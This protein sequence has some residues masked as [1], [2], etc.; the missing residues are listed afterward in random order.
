[1]EMNIQIYRYLD[2]QLDIYICLTLY[3][4]IVCFGVNEQYVVLYT[5]I[6]RQIMIYRYLDRQLDIYIYIL[7]FIDTLHCMLSE[8]T[9]Y[10]SI[11]IDIQI[12]RQIDSQ[13]YIYMSYL[14]LAHCVFWS[15]RTICSS[16]Y[17]D[18]QI[19]RQIVRYM[20]VLPCIGTLCVLE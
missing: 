12:F 19:F 2:R 15:E 18:I 3:W 17:I 7:S 1:M 11:Y 20:Y 16:G 13:I 8:R 4:H 10:S 6:Y 5:Q 14:V 9:K